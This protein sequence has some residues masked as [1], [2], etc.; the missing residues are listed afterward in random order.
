M[1]IHFLMMS[2]GNF[3][4]R[5]FQEDIVICTVLAAEK[6]GLN[7]VKATIN[8]NIY[9]SRTSLKTAEEGVSVFLF[10][11]QWPG[12]FIGLHFHTHYAMTH[13]YTA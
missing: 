12:L 11:H 9:I 13:T 7:F 8:N 5:I 10:H 4:K 1:H 6:N 2:N 3:Y